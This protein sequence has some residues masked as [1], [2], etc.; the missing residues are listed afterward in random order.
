MS[1]PCSGLCPVSS[2]LPCITMKGELNQ[3]ALC[4]VVSSFFKVV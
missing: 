3:V 2:L 4:R 1:F